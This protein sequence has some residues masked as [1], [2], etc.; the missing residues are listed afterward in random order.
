MVIDF[1]SATGL[2]L[3]HDTWAQKAS[4]FAS[5]IKT[6]C[7]VYTCK[8]NGGLTTWAHALEPKNGRPTLTPLGAPRQPGLGS[9]PKWVSRS[10]PALTAAN[11]RRCLREAR[12]KNPGKDPAGV[13]TIFNHFPCRPSWTARDR[14][15]LAAAAKERMDKY[16]VDVGAWQAN[17]VGPMPQHPSIFAFASVPPSEVLANHLEVWDRTSSSASSSGAHGTVPFIATSLRDHNMHG[18]NLLGSLVGRPE[19]LLSLQYGACWSLSALGCT[20]D[21]CLAS[22]K[23]VFS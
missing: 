1:E 21:A 2:Q 11:V 14:V 8:L 20:S 9:R 17:P 16:W 12:E 10:T 22:Q 4:K 18:S 13:Y 5:Y 6:L 3:P 23:A 7:R 15:L 19:N